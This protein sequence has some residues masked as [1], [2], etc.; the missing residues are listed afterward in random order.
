MHLVY[1]WG[2]QKF[3]IKIKSTCQE[4]DISIHLIKNLIKKD[5]KNKHIKVEVKPWLDNI[6]EAFFRYQGWHAPIIA[7]NDRLISQGKFVNLNVLRETIKE[8]LRK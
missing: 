7:V 4:C 2:G 1:F 6:F 3:G 5:F 8:E